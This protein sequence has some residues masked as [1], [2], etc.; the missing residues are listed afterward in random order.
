MPP[1]ATTQVGFTCKS[2][3]SKVITVED[4][5]CF[6]TKDQ[7]CSLF[8]FDKVVN[9][10]YSG[11]SG[12]T[13]LYNKV[14]KHKIQDQWPSRSACILM[15]GPSDTN[16]QRKES[17]LLSSDI[18]TNLALKTTKDLISRQ[19]DTRGQGLIYCSVLQVYQEELTDLMTIPTANLKGE[20]KKK[21]PYFNEDASQLNNCEQPLITVSGQICQPVRSMQD[22][23]QVLRVAQQNREVISKTYF[24]MSVID[25]RKRSHLIVRLI[26]EN[27]SAGFTPVIDFVELCGSDLAASASLASGSRASEKE[28]QFATSSF[29]SLS[30]A[31]LSAS[32]KNPFK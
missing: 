26:P 16:K 19:Q 25:M 21:V 7:Q 17:H 13:N 9:D 28:R 1:V 32:F 29:N 11:S 6:N 27:I 15:F 20:R 14:V 4:L 22:M 2:L 8:H 5:V 23:A 31:L 12:V 3:R 18:D 24:N 10:A 30:Q